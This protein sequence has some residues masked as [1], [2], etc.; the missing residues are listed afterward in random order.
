MYLQDR[1][2]EYIG[3][4]LNFEEITLVLNTLREKGEELNNIQTYCEFLSHKLESEKASHIAERVARFRQRPQALELAPFLGRTIFD[5]EEN[6][7]KIVHDLEYMGVFAALGY[8]G[9]TWATGVLHWG[10][11][12]KWS[13]TAVVAAYLYNQAKWFYL[14]YQWQAEFN[15]DETYIEVKEQIDAKMQRLDKVKKYVESLVSNLNS[16]ILDFSVFNAF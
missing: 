12:I 6:R 3:G 8:Y 11:S 13:H 9:I 15:N 7:A 10:E 14:D 2:D 5:N 1:L 16:R 4:K